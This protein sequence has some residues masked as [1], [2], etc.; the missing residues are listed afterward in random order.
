M[1]TRDLQIIQEF[2]LT[3]GRWSQT[4][5]TPLG[6]FAMTSFNG[7]LV[8]VGGMM[9]FSDR[10][11]VLN[12]ASRQWEQPYPKLPTGRR[13]LAATSYQH[14]LIAA[15]GR[16][17]FTRDLNKV[18]ILDATQIK[19]YT[20]ESVPVRACAM[21]SCRSGDTWYLSGEWVDDK[22]HVFSVS[23]PALIAQAKQQPKSK[24]ATPPVWQE[25]TCPPIKFPALTVIQNSLFIMGGKESKNIFHYNSQSKQWMIAGE[26]PVSLVHHFC[27]VLPSGSLLLGGGQNEVM[28]TLGW[29]KKVWIGKFEEPS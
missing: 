14:Y 8:L 1:S 18:E 13:Y 10:I 17:R 27:T 11:L 16:S 22:P 15:C 25:L 28:L 6:Y 3:T 19:W 20:A 4:L 29:S 24:T 9:P 7:Q 26:L 5:R 2:D 12:T 21:S 23:L